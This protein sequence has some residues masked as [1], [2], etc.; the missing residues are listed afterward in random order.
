MCCVHI[1]PRIFNNYLIIS[2]N[3]DHIS[4]RLCTNVKSPSDLL[5]QHLPSFKGTEQDLLRGVLHGF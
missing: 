1:D 4:G 5:T 2:L 3:P